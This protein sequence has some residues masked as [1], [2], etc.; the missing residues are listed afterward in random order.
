MRVDKLHKFT[1]FTMNVLGNLDQ[2]T[3]G[4]TAQIFSII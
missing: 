3:Y 1:D 2:L 4:D